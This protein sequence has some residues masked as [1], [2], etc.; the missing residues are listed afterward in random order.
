ME[1]EPPES[2]ESFESRTVW[3]FGSPRSG[4]TWLL[5]MLSNHPLVVPMNE[6][7]VGYHLSPFLHNEPGYRP[8]DLEFGNFT[9]RKVMEGDSAKF[10]AAEHSDVWLPGLRRLINDRLRAHV[11]R[12]PLRRAE[13]GSILVV[14]EPNGS[15]AADVIMQAQPEASL[16]FLLRDGRDVVDSELASF[17]VGGWL[18][19][20]FPHMKGVAPEDRLDFVTRSAYGWLWRTE[21]VQAAFAAHDGKKLTIRYEE[22]LATPEEHLAQIYDWMGIPLSP[23]EVKRVTD[24]LAFERLKKTGKGEFNR[25][26]SPGAW[27]Q[28]LLP[29]EQEAVERAIGPKLREL[30]YD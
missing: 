28:N 26:A 21:S 5:G 15:Q 12:N 24:Q 19:R 17:E 20:H 10:F 1:G 14:K 2:Q 9:I 29:E 25:S 22:M 7:T 11:E 3:I 13:S 18:E 27:R 6:P 30:G 8:E 4:S 16:L 23:E